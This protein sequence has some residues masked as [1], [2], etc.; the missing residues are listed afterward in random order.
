MSGGRIG[1]RMSN[2]PVLILLTTGRKSGN[3]ISTPLFYL[4]DGD[5]YAVAA[6]NGGSAGHPSWWLNLGADPLAAVEVD[7]SRI[8]VHAGELEGREKRRLWEGLV[9]MYPPY[10][11]YQKRTDRGIPVI[12]LKPIS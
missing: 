2:S 8:R 7:G 1:G 5:G 3:R 9:E 6:S 4:R 10:A 11:D 12:L